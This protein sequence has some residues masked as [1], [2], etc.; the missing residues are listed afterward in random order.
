MLE[1]HATAQRAREVGDAVGPGG[2]GGRR[3]VNESGS[4]R[5]VSATKAL[6]AGVASPWSGPPAPG[7]P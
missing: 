7:L 5:A 1:L 6:G 3:F 4:G 2:G